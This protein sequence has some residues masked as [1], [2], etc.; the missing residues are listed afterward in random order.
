MS[1][2]AQ[3][4][5]NRQNGRKSKGPV[6]REGKAISSVNA[7]KHGL[8]SRGVLAPDEDPAAFEALLERLHG[9]LNPV[10]QLEEDLVRRIA[11]Q[12]WRLRRVERVD[13]EV[14]AH[15]CDEVA[16]LAPIKEGKSALL[17][18]QLNEL[19]AYAAAKSVDRVGGMDT[20]KYR[21]VKAELE[22]QYAESQEAEQKL[23]ATLGAAFTEDAGKTNAFSKLTRYEAA[24]ERSLHR[25][26]HE[27]Q[28]LQAA[29]KGLLTAPPAAIDIDI[30]TG[31]RGLDQVGESV[32]DSA[33][34]EIANVA[35]KLTD[36]FS[37]EMVHGKLDEFA[38]PLLCGDPAVRPELPLESGSS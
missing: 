24:I 32:A 12:T 17:V 29:R 2:L 11:V 6:T 35:Q 15:Y 13:A 8:L 20:K 38:E 36:N 25:N 14:Y 5:A 37:V 27:L 7:R 23:S 26:L 21:A 10:G 4:K 9:E 28:R 16:N 3:I 22:E 18:Q 33:E 31:K 34:I 1:T 19:R 30:S